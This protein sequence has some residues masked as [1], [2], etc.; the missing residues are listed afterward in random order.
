MRHSPAHLHGL[1][2]QTR[3]KAQHENAN[4]TLFNFFCGFLFM[5]LSHR[6]TWLS[7]VA[8]N[9]GVSPASSSSSTPTPGFHGQA[10]F[11]IFFLLSPHHLPWPYSKR[12]LSD[13]GRYPP[14]E[15]KGSDS[16]HPGIPAIYRRP[17]PRQLRRLMCRLP[18]GRLLPDRLLRLGHSEDFLFDESM[19]LVHNMNQFW[20]CLRP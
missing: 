1:V 2:T 3:R 14:S 13:S 8:H 6:S 17:K 18:P 20:R 7:F 4:N 11:L 19:N 10:R 15:S 12:H 5:R 16:T 9:A